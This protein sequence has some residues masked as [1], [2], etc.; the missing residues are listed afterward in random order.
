MKQELDVSP[1]LV[2]GSGGIF[3]IEVHGQI[4]A[5]KT[6]EHGFPADDAIVDAVRAALQAG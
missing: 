2:K 4:V 6:R 3:V 1:E 5:R